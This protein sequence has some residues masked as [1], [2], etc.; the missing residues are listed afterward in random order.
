MAEHPHM[1]WFSVTAGSEFR[2]YYLPDHEDWMTMADWDRYRELTTMATTHHA[3][4]HCSD[5]P[6]IPLSDPKI[7]G[8]IEP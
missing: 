5:K 6:R 2:E 7:I 8:W 1:L 3:V 4:I